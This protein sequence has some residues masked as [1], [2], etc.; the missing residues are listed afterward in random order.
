MSSAYCTYADVSG[1]FK[2]LSFSLTSLVTS[3]QVTQFITEA[4]AYM[5]SKIGQKYVVPI[6]GTTSLIIMKTISIYI[7]CD[8]VRKILEVKTG[9]AGKDQAGDKGETEMANAMINDIVKGDLNLIDSTLAS[10]V[11]GV[12]SYTYDNSTS[13]TFDVGTASW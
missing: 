13:T 3:S 7:V 8:R 11:D 4:S 1:E 12:E 10:S 5:D 2:S 6:T 9:D